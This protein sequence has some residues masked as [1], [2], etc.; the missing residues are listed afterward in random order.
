MILGM[1]GWGSI[2]IM[3][4]WGLIIYFLIK[5]FKKGNKNGL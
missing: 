4:V 2:S 3:I 1:I 5:W